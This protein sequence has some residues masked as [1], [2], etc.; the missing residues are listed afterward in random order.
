MCIALATCYQVPQLPKACPEP[1]PDLHPWNEIVDDA[2]CRHLSTHCCCR[3]RLKAL[4]CFHAQL[5]PCT[6]INAAVLQA[7]QDCYS[8]SSSK[9]L[10]VGSQ[11]PIWLQLALTLALLH[12]P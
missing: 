8:C 3:V 12:R 6:N 1:P 5:G 4:S 2:C 11:V 7:L 10:E 9:L